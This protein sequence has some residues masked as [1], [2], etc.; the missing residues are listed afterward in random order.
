M[1]V[2]I[3]KASKNDV[4]MTTKVYAKCGDLIIKYFILLAGDPRILEAGLVRYA[5]S[6]VAEQLKTL[7]KLMDF[8]KF[9]P[10]WSNIL[11]N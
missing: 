9:T 10:I 7:M 1:L 6:L 8:N 2:S 4:V 3:L 5:F 11:R